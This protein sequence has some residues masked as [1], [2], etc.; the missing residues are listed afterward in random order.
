MAVVVFGSTLRASGG[1][2]SGPAAFPFFSC[3]S[4]SS[5]SALDGGL[6]LTSSRSPSLAVVFAISVG[7]GLFRM[8]QICSTHLVLYPCSVLM[9]TPS[10]LLTGF[11]WLLLFPD[12]VL[13]MSYRLL[14]SFAYSTFCFCGKSIVELLLVFLGTFFTFL[15][16]YQ[17]IKV[18]LLFLVCSLHLLILTFKR[19]LCVIIF[20]V[21][22]ESHSFL[23]S[24]PFAQDF[25]AELLPGVF[26]CFLVTVCAFFHRFKG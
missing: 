12:F 20:H 17:Y 18:K 2:Q 19:F 21:S 4:A 15:L 25:I 8:S 16:S 3:F 7:G 23:C 9:V 24:F 6:T 13:V 22:N 5:I 26:Q 14:V 11:D 10:F 1:M